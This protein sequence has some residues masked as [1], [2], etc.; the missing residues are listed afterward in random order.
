[1]NEFTESSK[2]YIGTSDIEF[3]LSLSEC[4]TSSMTSKIGNSGSVVQSNNS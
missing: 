3:S 1:M 4:N 2:E